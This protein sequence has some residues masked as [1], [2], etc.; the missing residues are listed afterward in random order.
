MSTLISALALGSIYALVALGYNVIYLTTKV[1]NFAQGAIVAV[2]ALVGYSAIVLWGVPVAVAILICGATGVILASVEQ[3]LVVRPIL[4]R[5]GDSHMWL[6]S[7]LGASVVLEA[8]ALLIWGPDPQRVTIGVLEK[9]V[10]VG[11]ANVTVAA[12]FAIFC[13]VL[14]TF[15]LDAWYDRTRTGKVMRAA[16]E[17]AEAAELRGIDTKRL[18]LASFALAGMISGVVALILVPITYAQPLLGSAFAIKAFVAMAIGGFGSNRGALIGGLVVGL[19]ETYGGHWL[20]LQYGDPL[21]FVVLLG[22]LLFHPRGLFGGPQERV[23]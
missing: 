23:V 3:I 22:L 16:A 9:F 15:A 4:S 17:D 8:G 18:A 12:P 10:W 6:V 20:G 19:V 5:R 14:G 2:C 1:F 11:D 13:A 21:V 7:T